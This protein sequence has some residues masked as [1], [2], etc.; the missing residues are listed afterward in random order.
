MVTYDEK[1]LVNDTALMDRYDDFFTRAGDYASNRSAQ[2]RVD[3]SVRAA[4][5]IL[6]WMPKTPVDEIYEYFNIDFETAQ[7]PTECS[8]YNAFGN[9]EG[10]FAP[11][12]NLVLDQRGFKYIFR[13]EAAS[14][15]NG[16]DDKRI[17]YDT[18]VKKVSYSAE[19]VTIETDK[20]RKF[21]TEYAI[22]TLSLGVLQHTDV[23]WEPAFPEWK[24]E[25]LYAFG[26]ATY[27]KI[28]LNFPDQFWSDNQYMLWADPNVRGRYGIWQSLNSP[29]FLPQNGS[30]NI[31]FVTVTDT[32]SYRVESMSDADVQDEIM[33]LLRSIYGND[34][35][36]PDA[37]YFPRWHS[38]PL[39]RGSYSNWPIG[40]LD[41]HH[42]NMRAP[43]SD[44]LFFTGEAMSKPYFGF[45]QG[46]WIEGN[47]TG[48]SVVGCL[49]GNCP[50][51]P[52]H[53]VLDNC[54]QPVTMTKRS[55]I[56]WRTKSHFSS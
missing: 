16:L 21:H 23:T 30:T 27:T 7:P 42:D 39:Y 3:L 32:A 8:F 56:E 10:G 41:G 17:H 51:Y 6:G 36:D 12:N 46:A 20:G 48:H 33:V 34:I 2:G 24:K 54:K 19:G 29:G 49:K 40:E 15:L 45:L 31:F 9:T 18:T 13:S 50:A 47:T 44:R 28:F 11:G 52:Y 43:L 38:D 22:S 1:G 5:S 14:F 35:P 55:E 26:M 25:G 53:A 37:F 4:S